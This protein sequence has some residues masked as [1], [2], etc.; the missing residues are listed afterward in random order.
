MVYVLAM[1]LFTL[2]TGK[3]I[4]QDT[5]KE[6][7]SACCVN[8]DFLDQ[9]D[10]PEHATSGIPRTIRQRS[11]RVNFPPTSKP[12]GKYRSRHPHRFAHPGTLSA[13]L[14]KAGFSQVEE[15]SPT[16]PWIWPGTPVGYWESRRNQGA[17]FPRMIEGLTP[18]QREKVF[19]EVVNSI[20]E[21]YDGTQ[22]NFTAQ[23]VLAS[24]VR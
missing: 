19:T 2:L 14:R 8:R 1:M 15:E 20:E 3:E 11:E 17:L 9:V 4:H 22:L 13:A 18:E 5:V 12:N 24:A 23:I 21:Y 16:L 7:A 6:A 10:F